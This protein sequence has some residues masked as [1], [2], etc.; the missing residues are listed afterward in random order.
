M[1]LPAMLARQ[2]AAQRGAA[3]AIFIRDGFV[4][5]ASASNVFAAL[6]GVVITPILSN[7]LLAG[8]T[9]SAMLDLYAREGIAA[10]EASL[11]HDELRRADEIFLTSTNGELRPIVELDGQPVGAGRVG[12]VFQ[13]SIELFDAAT[14]RLVRV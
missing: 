14:R 2:R 12:P 6:D 3:D 5:E 4:T 1:L 11:S 7:Y 8:V 13:R 10:R 9:W